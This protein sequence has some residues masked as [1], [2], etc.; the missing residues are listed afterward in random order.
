MPYHNVA[1]HVV[2]VAMPFYNVAMHVVYVA[3]PP[4][5]VA[6]RVALLPDQLPPPQP[7]PRGS[8][9]SPC[10]I[11]RVPRL[12]RVPGTTLQVPWPLEGTHRLVPLPQ[13]RGPSLL[14]P[15]LLGHITHLRT[16]PSC[17]PH[18]DLMSQVINVV[19]VYT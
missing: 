12:P 11:S 16:Q 19:R 9:R 8:T 14:G 18:R 5:N 17:K 13:Q 7:P 10:P 2:Y 1:I 15:S 4:S 3:M 6:I